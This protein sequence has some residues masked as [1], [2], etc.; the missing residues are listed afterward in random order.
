M[1]FVIEG[2]GPQLAPALERE[3]VAAGHE[4][5][6]PAQLAVIGIDAPTGDDLVDVEQARW[7]ETVASLRS[8]FGTVRRVAAAMV[9][10]EEGRILVLVPVH[11]QRPSRACGLAAVAGSFMT[12][13][14]QVAAVEL[15][16]TGIR[17][18]VVAVGP[19]AGS[20]PD[21]VADGV[22]IG[23]LLRPEEV[24]QACCL[25]ASDAAGAVNGAVLTVDGGY[26][27]TKALG[28]SPYAR[29]A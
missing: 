19:L 7:Q 8:A 21:A 14:A 4:P 17:V 22:P 20:D 24:G 3:L 28:G 16:P 9:E 1:R 25:L 23:R 5:G 29:T 26:A 15:A 12:T 18:N 10:A 11:A 6:D 27:V 13:V 2:V